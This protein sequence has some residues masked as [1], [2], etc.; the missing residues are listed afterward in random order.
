MKMIP[1]DAY[2]TK[3]KALPPFT[4]DRES[5]REEAENYFAVVARLNDKWRVIICRDG[6]QWILQRR[7]GFRQGL[8]RWEA[9]TFNRN[10]NGL[11]CRVNQLAGE[12]D[13]VAM[14]ALENLPEHFGGRA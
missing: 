14:R 2:L 12:C 11:L 5:H 9:R 13:A 4:P 3:Q 1:A 7:A 10:R 6:I 8:A